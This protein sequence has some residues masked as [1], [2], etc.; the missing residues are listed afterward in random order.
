M[1]YTLST[2]LL[3]GEERE[4]IRLLAGR[5]M[6]EVKVSDTPLFWPHIEG[7]LYVSGKISVTRNSDYVKIEMRG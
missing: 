7:R 6:A 3:E 5:P 1:T 2:E 4:A